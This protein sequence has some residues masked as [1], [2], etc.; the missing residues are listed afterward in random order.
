[1]VGVCV[2]P[3]AL[4]QSSIS[5]NGLLDLSLGSIKSPGDERSQ[6]NVSSGSMT[7]SWF[8][9]RGAEDLGG[10][11]SVIFQLE[12]F[13]RAD[14]GEQGR[15]AGD[16]FW[17]RNSFVGFSSTD[18]GRLTFGHHGTPLFVNSLRFNGVEGSFGYSPTIRHYFTSGTVTGDSVWSDSVV[19]TSPTVSGFTVGAST[20][21]SEGDGGG[22]VGANATF[23]KSGLGLGV[24]W[25]KVKKGIA[26]QDSETWQLSGSYDT[27]AFKL[28][29]QT[30]RVKN[31][32]TANHFDIHGLGVSVPFGA[33]RFFFQNSVLLNANGADRR[34]LT[35]GYAHFLSKRTDVYIVGMRDRLQ[36]VSAGRSFSVGMRHRF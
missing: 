27:G 15:F 12:S 3:S 32:S 35:A 4:A 34:T 9:L 22:N 1:M 30:G 17:S 29:A 11:L 7:T 10:G 2:A 23:F 33:G 24:A 31:T 16:A 18:W 21:M 25:Q 8:G 14:T 20:A 13:I 36:N 26:V 6:T 28:F 19:Y 5:F